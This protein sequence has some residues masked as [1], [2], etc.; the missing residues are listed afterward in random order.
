MQG[1]ASRSPGLNRVL[2]GSRPASR[3]ALI[4]SVL[5]VLVAAGCGG[6]DR[7]DSFPQHDER[8]PPDSGREFF[9]GKLVL[10]EGCLRVDAPP[11][12]S[13]SPESLLVIWPRSFTLITEDGSVRVVDAVGRIAA[14][15]GDH[16]RFGGYP[17]GPQTVRIRE[18]GK[19]LRTGCP[20]P[21]L[22]AGDEVVAFSLD[23]PT[24]LTL[25][26][27]DSELH[28]PRQETILGGQES[29]TAE[30]VGELVLEGQCLR[31][32]A[33]HDDRT[34]F[35][36]WPPGFTPHDHRGV[37]HVRNGA[38]RVIAQVGDRLRMGG[39]YS[40]WGDEKCP[41]PKFGANSIKVLSE[42]ESP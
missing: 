7:V 4:V 37:V 30:A 16:V 20:G 1:P 19:E 34:Y 12:D 11:P 15:V 17:S 26:L 5:L 28:F 2:T 32:K 25:Q 24:T 36:V 38:G 29:V 23:G 3:Q 39:G 42:S 18:L 9:A 40:R 31:L 21:Y 13:I 41:G 33:D 22:W 10:K 14:R 27:P 8:I 6:Q 35:I